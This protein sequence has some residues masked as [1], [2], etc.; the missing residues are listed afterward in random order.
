MKRWLWIVAVV[1]GSLI[2]PWTALA[3]SGGPD[4]ATARELLAHVADLPPIL[5]VQARDGTLTVCLDVEPATLQR[6]NGAAVERLEATV[7]RTLTPLDWRV[8]HVHAQDPADGRCKP[9]SDFLPRTEIAALTE[10]QTERITPAPSPLADVFPRS[11][12]GKT[13]FV[14]AGHGWE[15]NGWDWRT[16]RPPYQEFI[17]DHNNAEVV[18]QYLIPYLENAGATVISV[19]ERDWNAARVVVDDED[20][21]F[22]ADE[23]WHVSAQPGYAGGAYHFA[24]TV[25]ASATATATWALDVSQQGAYALYAWIASD[26]NRAPDA[27]YVVHHAAGAS[28]VR[29]DQ[30][31][32]PDTWRY[33]GTF[34]AYAAPLTV[35][36]DNA[37]TEAGA[38]VVA[39]ALRLGGG[40][41]DDLNG[42]ETS[43][44]SAPNEPWWETCTFYYSQWMGMDQPYGD[45]T[46]RPTYARWQHAGVDEDAVYVSWHTNGYNGDN[47]VISG[48][49]SYVHDGSTYPLTAGSEEL[50]H[51]V[52]TEL[53]SDIRAGWETGWRD[54]GQRAR[55]LGE[56]RML[57]DDDP[58]NRLPGVLLEIGY[59]DNVHDANAL[60]EPRFNRLAARAVYQGIVHYFE[61]QDDMDLVKAPE[62]PTHLRVQNLGGG[63]LR[64]AWRPSPTDADGLLGDPATGYRVYTSP[65]GFAWS[66]PRPVTNL[67]MTLSGFS[68]SET[69]YVRVTATN[70]GGE[71]FPTETLGARVGATPPLLIVNGFDK[72][73][74]FGLVEQID[75]LGRYNLRMWLPQINGRGYV[76][77]HGDAVPPAYAWD[78][79]SNEAVADDLVSLGAYPMVDWILG[80]ESLEEDGTLNA[81]EQ[82]ALTDFV[83]GGGALLISGSELLWDLVDQGSGATFATDVLRTGYASDD[84]ETYQATPVAGAA[85]A[86]LPAFSFDAPGEYD[87]DVPDVLTALDGATP[88]LTYAGDP[89]RPAAVQYADGCE[90]TLVLGLPFEVIQPAARPDVMVHVL[91]FLDACVTPAVDALES[92]ITSPEDGIYTATLPLF[93]GWAAGNGLRRVEVQVLD[94]TGATWDGSDWVTPTTWLTATGAVSWTY[95]LP[96]LADGPYTLKAQAVATETEATPSQVAFTLDTVA[97]VTPTLITPTRAVTLTGLTATLRWTPPPDDGAPLSYDLALDG[98]TRTVGVPTYTTRVANGEHVWRVRAVDAAGHVGPWSAA[99]RFTVSRAAVFLPLILR[100]YAPAQTPPADCEAWLVED[101]EAESDWIFNTQAELIN[102]PAHDGDRAARVGIPPGAPG[103]GQAQYSSLMRTLALPADAASITLTYWAYPSAENGD[104]GDFHY[105]GPQPALAVDRADSR[106]WEARTVDLSAYAGESVLFFFG[107]KNDGDDDTAA[108]V[109]DDIAIEVCR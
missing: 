91:D 11:L 36:L 71:S 78:S 90:R 49:V 72:L 13:I 77:H 52:H 104:A 101:F 12:A 99:A 96:A 3:E 32:R 38:T 57:W 68:E 6:D 16:Q 26:P 29:L 59:H 81:A 106:A 43:A 27:H 42:I 39:D 92:G 24:Q 94:A 40:V 28:E 80:E 53:V 9:L 63:E 25:T 14:S 2:A 55:N 107:T 20:D 1:G 58:A 87:A 7:A 69:V 66:D 44:P 64:L 35:T 109:I 56:V 93:E 15:W 82:A 85:F 48:T 105:V 86:G 103:T 17:E 10:P 33:L 108:L 46:A 60:K 23:R 50:Q 54:L 84:A 51:A 76:V 8:L 41:F 61:E 47:D 31:I 4:P 62:P 102:D 95:A 19:R 70:D 83:H 18:N 97:P 30:R 34:P 100:N 37:S 74:R 88:A 21:A 79:A 65:D 89:E 45:V 5:D 98:I 73:N 67:E 22:T 75:T